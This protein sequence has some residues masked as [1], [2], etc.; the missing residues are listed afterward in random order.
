M[1]VAAATYLVQATSQAFASTGV[2]D[3]EAPKTAEASVGRGSWATG[4][5]VDIPGLLLKNEEI[6]K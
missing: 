3:M 4:L 5:R 2:P 6:M 1:F